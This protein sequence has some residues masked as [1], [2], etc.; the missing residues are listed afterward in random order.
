MSNGSEFYNR[1]DRVLI[2]EFNELPEVRAMVDH[3]MGGAAVHVFI[4]GRDYGLR[5]LS[6][7]I[8][9]GL[10]TPIEVDEDGFDAS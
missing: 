10:L 6:E 7:P 4:D 3:D 1:G 5:R 2:A 8:P 9:R